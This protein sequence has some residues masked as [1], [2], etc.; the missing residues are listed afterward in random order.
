MA[1]AEALEHNTT[2]QTL[3]LANCDLSLTSLIAITTSL[4]SNNTLLNLTLDRPLLTS[5][6]DDMTH[7]LSSLVNCPSLSLHSLSL[8]YC[9]LSDMG[10]T[11]FSRELL[12]NKTLIALNLEW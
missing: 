6:G 7:T 3:S 10:V 9:K 4:Y 2:L 5:P 12:T 11:L 8:K 1:I